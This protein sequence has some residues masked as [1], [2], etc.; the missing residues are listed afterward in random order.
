MHTLHVG[1]TAIEFQMKRRRRTR[2]ITVR[3]HRDGAVI[4][5]RPY[6]VTNKD[7]FAFVERHADWIIETQNEA[8]ITHAD[9][10]NHSRDHYLKYK[11]HARSVITER[12]AYWNQYYN[13]EVNRISIRQART[14]W[15]S[16]SSKGNL[17]FNYKL[18]FLP[19]ELQDYVIVHE[20]CHLKELNHGQDFWRLV[21]KQIPNYRRL[22]TRLQTE[23]F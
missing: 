8:P 18:L 2:S 15:G 13:F 7:V 21:S 10:R 4:V 11:E 1:D 19:E 9:I 5:T 12:V 20:L 16:C 3:V 6:W 23:Q 14:R 22:R 17:S